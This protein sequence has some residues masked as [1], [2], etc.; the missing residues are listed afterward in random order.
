MA[1]WKDNAD[2][3]ICSNCGYEVNNPA[4]LE[5]QGKICPCCGERMLSVGC[6][7][8][9]MVKLLQGVRELVE[10]EYGRAGAKWG[11]KNNSNHE[12]YAV[13]LE[14]VDEAREDL[15]IIEKTL[16][17]F[18]SMIRADDSDTDMLI[19]INGIQ[20]YAESLAA[21]AIQVAAMAKKAKA[22]ICDGPAFKELTGR[23]PK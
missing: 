19:H 2:S 9:K 17:K 7:P 23:D 16:K 22:T 20:A 13:L 4:S 10:E 14:E 5:S 15:D 1:Y 12:S 3:Y 11:L 8:P 18:W 6:E 21:E